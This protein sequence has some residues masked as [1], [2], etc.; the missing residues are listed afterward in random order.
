MQKNFIK[1]DTKLKGRKGFFL[2]FP[3]N[4]NKIIITSCTLPYLKLSMNL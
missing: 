3:E 1:L 2:V 4:L